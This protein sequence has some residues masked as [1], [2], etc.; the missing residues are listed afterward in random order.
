MDMTKS[1]GGEPLQEESVTRAESKPTRARKF[2]QGPAFR[3]ERVFETMALSCGKINSTQFQ[4][5]NGGRET[6][7]Y[8]PGPRWGGGLPGGVSRRGGGLG[9]LK[10]KAGRG[11]W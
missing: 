5:R 8:G 1:T 4:C 6:S 2:Y 10:N 7:Y 9:E 3:F 11:G